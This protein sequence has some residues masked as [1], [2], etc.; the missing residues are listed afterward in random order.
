MNA[1]QPMQPGEMPRR[2][3]HRGLRPLRTLW[4]LPLTL[5]G[6]LVY[7]LVLMTG[8]QRHR[9]SGA[10]AISGGISSWWMRRGPWRKR[11]LLAITI[12]H[13]IITRDAAG[14]HRTLAHELE[15]VRQGERWGIF[16]P[17]AYIVASLAAMAKGGHYYDDNCFETAACRAAAIEKIRKDRSTTIYLD[18]C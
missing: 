2:S 17:P 18:G 13:V 15:H 10:L 7:G 1:L 6:L 11:N 12:G 9:C 8:G 16:F 4:A 14:F 3:I 5:P